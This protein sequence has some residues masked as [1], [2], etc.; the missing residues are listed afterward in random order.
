MSL[1]ARATMD[2]RGVVCDV[3]ARADVVR[4]PAT[5]FIVRSVFRADTD[6]VATR[7]DG[8]VATVF[9]FTRWVVV[10]VRVVGD[11]FCTRDAAKPP[12]VKNKQKI[13]NIPILL[14]SQDKC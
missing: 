1:A 6:C 2:A 3:V 4:V 8:R 9:V 11:V 7:T 5:E 13:K 10:A 12:V 14:I